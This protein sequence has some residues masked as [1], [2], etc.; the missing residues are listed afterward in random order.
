MHMKNELKQRRTQPH[1]SSLNETL[2][3]E[4]LKNWTGW[5][6]SNLISMLKIII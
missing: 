4:E 5:S 3:G 1:L 2:D 6:K